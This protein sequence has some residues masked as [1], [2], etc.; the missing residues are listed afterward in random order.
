M[1]YYLKLG[2]ILFIFSVVASGILAF[3]NSLTTPIIAAKKAQDEIDAREKLIPGAIFEEHETAD[4]ESYFIALV[5]DGEPIG[6]VFIA[7]ENGYSSKILTMVGVDADFNI[8]GIEILDQS[9]TPGLGANCE[10]ESFT[11][12]FVEKEA[13]NLKVNQDD[14][15]IT[16]LAGATITSRTIA[17]SIRERANSLKLALETGGEQ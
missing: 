16:S 1:K 8:I 14:G 3:V 10:N 9:E 17:N 2:L 11:A 12:Q 4:G 15:E 5:E 6:F 7:S 13:L